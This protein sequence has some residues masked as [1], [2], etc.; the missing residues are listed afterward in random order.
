MKNVPVVLFFSCVKSPAFKQSLS[1]LKHFI[2][3]FSTTQFCIS[4]FFIKNLTLYKKAQIPTKLCTQ[5]CIPDLLA[6]LRI[7]FYQKS[8]QIS[9]FS[10]QKVGSGAL[11]MVILANNERNW[12]FYNLK[13]HVQQKA[14]GCTRC[15]YI[16]AWT[17]L[18][19]CVGDV[20]KEFLFSGKPQ[21]ACLKRIF[22]ANFVFATNTLTASI[23]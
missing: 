8:I 7:F 10:W 14:N 11:Q 18:C 2:S 9:L 4:I 12:L 13:H 1:M 20:M 17:G 5:R 21:S 6:R 16:A 19:G 3:N 15:V 23:F 22:F